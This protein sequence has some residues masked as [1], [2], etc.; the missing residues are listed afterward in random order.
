MMLSQYSKALEDAR[1]SVQI[2]A[3]FVKG[4]IRIAKCCMTLGD[5][6]GAKSA[7]QHA[8]SIDPRNTTL[9]TERHNLESLEKFQENAE[10]ALSDKDY[11][12]VS[13]AGR[14]KNAAMLRV[15]QLMY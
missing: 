13:M 7:L 10:K 15:N 4:Y 6:G 11:R 12:K 5:V 3:N 1:T 2:D 14:T 8:S 9:S